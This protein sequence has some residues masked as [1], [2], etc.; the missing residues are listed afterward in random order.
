[1]A[2]SV[3]SISFALEDL[4]FLASLCSSSLQP[5]SSSSSSFSFLNDRFVL[6]GQLSLPARGERDEGRP[7]T[8]TGQKR[9]LKQTVPRGGL[10]RA[11]SPGGG[12]GSNLGNPKQPEENKV[13]HNAGRV[14]RI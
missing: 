10:G 8:I 6:F 7:E 3:V 11:Q 9:G 4:L 1:M 13:Q 14:S 2:G 5:V 12:Q